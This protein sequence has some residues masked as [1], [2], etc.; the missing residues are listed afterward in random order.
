[1]LQSTVHVQISTRRLYRLG[2]NQVLKKLL[3]MEN[4][5]NRRENSR[6]SAVGNQ[7]K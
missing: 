1:M 6:K 5:E 3:R 7:E 4:H 2:R